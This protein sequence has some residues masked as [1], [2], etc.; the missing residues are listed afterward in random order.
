MTGRLFCLLCFLAVTP[1][2]TTVSTVSFYSVSLLLQQDTLRK[3][4]EIRGIQGNDRQLS[5]ITRCFNPETQSITLER[6][7]FGFPDGESGPVPEW[8]VD[9]LSGSGGWPLSLVTAFPALREGMTMEYRVEI[10]DWS[11]NWREGAWG[12]FSPSVKGLRPDTCKFS[13]TGDLIENLHW[14]GTGYRVSRDSG[15]V[16]FIATDS[17][18]VLVISPFSTYTELENFI[19]GKISPALESEYPPDLREAALQSTSAGADEYAQSVRAKSLLCNSINRTAAVPGININTVHSIQEILDRRRGTALEISLVFAAMC[20]ELGMQADILPASDTDYG[21]PVPTGW[22]RYLVRLES[23]DGHEWIM[24]P[25]A[26]LTSASYIYRPDTLYVIE[27]GNIQVMPPNDSM[28]S[29]NIEE[30]YI[31]SE[32]GTFTMKMNC[33]GWY[34]MML[35]RKLAGL[36][37]E[38]TLLSLSEWS[39]LSGRTIVPDSC[40]LS[41]PFDLG[42]NMSLSVIGTLWITTDNSITA[43]Y[44]PAFNWSK[45]EDLQS[46]SIRKWFLAGIR[47]A[48]SPNF[49]LI[50]I[51]DDTVVITDTSGTP[52]PIPVFIGV[53]E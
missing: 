1:A 15:K 50:D 49:P 46:I 48:C 42:T 19:L 39:W 31:N 25:S 29:R 51:I 47:N 24:E 34:D 40:S 21:I 18:G 6:A 12:V 32:E 26:N 22:N 17:A 13:V 33:T 8:S 7:V 35:R 23:K 11:E 45:P 5:R 41:D 28:E 14:N 37:M 53:T 10:T 16:E 44:L 2:R 20:R 9:T 4:I 43:E 30:W 3:I 27:N 36:S 52:G 38:R